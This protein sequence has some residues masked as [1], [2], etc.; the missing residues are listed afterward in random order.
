MT[1]FLIIVLLDAESIEYHSVSADQCSPEFNIEDNIENVTIVSTSTTDSDVQISIP[2]S[3][4]SNVNSEGKISYFSVRAAHVTN[5]FFV[6]VFVNLF[7]NRTSIFP[8][9]RHRFWMLRNR[10]MKEMTKVSFI[11][12]SQRIDAPIVNNFLYPNSSML[13]LNAFQNRVFTFRFRWP[14]FQMLRLS[15]KKI[16]KVKFRVNFPR[17]RITKKIFVPTIIHEFYYFRYQ[18]LKSEILQSIS[19][20]RNGSITFPNCKY[21]V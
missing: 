17:V 6:R 20:Y 8:F 14:Y 13:F 10:L 16:A 9:R 19:K 2:S 1:L 15:M 21:F 5:T 11:T 3:S 18:E 7:Q 12:T 4:F